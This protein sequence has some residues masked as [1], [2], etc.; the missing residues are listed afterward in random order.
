VDKSMVATDGAYAPLLVAQTV[1]V[2]D[3]QPL[4]TQPSLQGESITALKQI[5][6]SPITRTNWSASL[7]PPIE[8]S[9]IPCILNSQQEIEIHMPY[10]EMCSRLIDELINNGW[11]VIDAVAGCQ[12]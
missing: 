4:T 8:F 6:V 5:A 9:W 7:T 11:Q 2:S 1:E 12:C 3:L 10:F